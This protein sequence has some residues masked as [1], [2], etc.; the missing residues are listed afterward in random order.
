MYHVFIDNKMVVK[1]AS[2]VFSKTV[3]AAI[4][5]LRDDLKVEQFKGSEATT[6][7]IRKI[8]DLFDFE[9]STSKFGRGLQSPVKPEDFGYIEEICRYLCSIRDGKNKL[10]IKGLRQTG[11]VGKT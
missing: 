9:N 3:A 7:F 10:L 11:F 5:H 6:N 8:N 4:D 2:Q 1:F